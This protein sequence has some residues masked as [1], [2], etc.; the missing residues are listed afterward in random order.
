MKRSLVNEMRR[1]KHRDKKND[2]LTLRAMSAT[3]EI[4]VKSCRFSVGKDKY[5]WNE[6]GH[7]GK[8]GADMSF[9]LNGSA[10]VRATEVPRKKSAHFCLISTEFAT[11]S[12]DGKY[13]QG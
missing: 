11:Y 13:R 7:S 3:T 8:G 6:S 9:W 4:F 12:G 2:E 10:A 1:E 5:R